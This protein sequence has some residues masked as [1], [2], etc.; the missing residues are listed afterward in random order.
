MPNRAKPVKL[1]IQL[2]SPFESEMS[3]DDRHASFRSL[4]GRP[5]ILVAIGFGLGYLARFMLGPPESELD[6]LNRQ[7]E[8]PMPAVK[9]EIDLPLKP[10]SSS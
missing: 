8:R 4:L 2:R 9:P 3:L 6:G 7:F 10:K 1:M 5:Y